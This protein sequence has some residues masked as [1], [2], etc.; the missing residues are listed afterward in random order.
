[1][2]RATFH[3]VVGVK[4]VSGR[5]RQLGR[6]CRSNILIDL[7]LFALVPKRMATYIYTR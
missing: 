5:T 3:D 7:L 2:V 1:M 6:V 4:E